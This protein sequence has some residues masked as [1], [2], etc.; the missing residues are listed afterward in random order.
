MENV[1]FRHKIP[2]LILVK[3]ECTTTQSLGR[4]ISWTLSKLRLKLLR[5]KIN[6]IRNPCHY[7]FFFL[8]MSLGT[9]EQMINSMVFSMQ[10]KRTHQEKSDNYYNVPVT[11]SCNSCSASR[12][13]Q[14]VPPPPPPVSTYCPSSVAPPCSLHPVP[15]Y[16]YQTPGQ[17]VYINPHAMPHSKSLDHPS[18]KIRQ[19]R[20]YSLDQPAYEYA[21]S[22]GYGNYDCVDG[23]APACASFSAYNTAGNR[24]PLPGGFPL[25]GLNQPCDS[26]NGQH[27]AP[28]MVING[29]TY[30]HR[31]SSGNCY[32][33]QPDHV[34]YPEYQGCN[35]CGDKRPKGSA[36]LRGE[37]LIDLG[38]YRDYQQPFD[39][40]SISNGELSDYYH[41][42]K[43]AQKVSAILLSDFY[44]MINIVT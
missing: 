42:V 1:I 24:Y 3:Q 37:N 5:G 36:G 38:D 8:A 19:H 32:H 11:N 12:Q 6:N 35:F 21:R 15:N 43:V 22:P 9:P 40:T 7:S 26:V 25:A 23:Y 27:L 33:Q 28:P 39:A 31:N 10:E 13:Y 4:Q 17:G 41:R 34:C 29:S 16:G 2:P 30:G 14:L 44:L 18:E 20:H